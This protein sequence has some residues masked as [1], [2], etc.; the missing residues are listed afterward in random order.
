MKGIHKLTVA[1]LSVVAVSTWNT[2][3]ATSMTIDVEGTDSASHSGAITVGILNKTNAGSLALSGANAIGNLDIEGGK[4]SVSSASNLNGASSAVTFAASG[5]DPVTSAANTA[6]LEIA[7]SM[8]T[9]AFAFLTAG[10]VQVDGS[11]VAT[12]N[13]AP[14]GTG[15][16]CKTGTGVMKVASDLGPASTTTSFD[17]T[18]GFFE[19]GSNQI[20]WPSNFASYVPYGMTDGNPNWHTDDTSNQGITYGGLS[21]NH[22]Y[23]PSLGGSGYVYWQFLSN[24]TGAHPTTTVPTP[25]AGINV[26]AGTLYVQSGKAPNAPI[27]I[28]N[29]AALQLAGVDESAESEVTSALT[30]QSGGSI[31]VDADVSVGNALSV[32]TTYTFNTDTGYYANGAAVIAWPASLTDFDNGTEIPGETNGPFSIWLTTDTSDQHR[33]Y[34]GVNLN[35]FDPG[36]FYWATR[37]VYYSDDATLSAVRPTTTVSTGM[38]AALS[39]TVLFESGSKLVLGAGSNYTRN[40]QVGTAS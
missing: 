37:Y 13:A 14:T 19:S 1:L 9:G 20:A 4:V 3:F 11:Y 23:N 17:I 32:T 12:L 16:V 15:L 7:G 25:I 2:T 27:Q 8:N 21:M 34:G 36:G 24:L 18:D 22:A 30:V 26:D 10:T 39:G 28:A 31:E 38:D 33:S 5:I 29:G 40:M 6:T 35:F